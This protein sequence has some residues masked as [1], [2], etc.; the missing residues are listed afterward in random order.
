MVRKR[1]AVFLGMLAACMAAEM[2][3]AG[4]VSAQ[5]PASGDWFAFQPEHDEFG[6]AMLDLREVLNEPVA[7][8]RGRVRARGDALVF[9]K[10]GEPVRF[11]GVVI[12]SWSWPTDHAEIDYLARRLA[13]VGVNLVRVHIPRGNADPAGFL[14]TVHY[15]THAFKQ[16]GIYVYL[17]WFCTANQGDY[18]NLFYFDA[19]AQEQ[20]RAWARSILAPGNP[21]TGMSLATDPAVAAVELLDEDS[22][23]F[24]T[25]N[26]ERRAELAAKMPVLERRFGDWLA[27][28][29]GSLERAAAAWG[30]E[31]YPKGDDFAAGRAAMY[32]AY[33]LT[34]ADWAP[35]QRNAARARD[36]A[37]FMAELMRDFYGGTKAWMREELGYDGLV[38]GSNWKTADERVLGPL[39]QYANM[40]C[41]LTARN[42][43][44]SGGL[45]GPGPRHRIQQGQ[46]Y[47]NLSLLRAPEQAILMHLQV[48]GYPHMLTEGGWVAPNRFRAEE[49]FLVAGY[50]SLQGIDGYCPF[51]V[52]KDWLARQDKWPIQRPSTLG[53]YPAASVIYR[54]G[55]VR[56]GP[57]VINDV[58]S[59]DDLYALKG[60]AL[61]QPLGLDA[62]Q[63]A[64]VPEGIQAEVESLPGVD[65][66]SFYVGRVVRTIREKQG[67][68]TFMNTSKLI[69]R[70]ARVVRSA[71]GELVLDY[72]K[73]LVTMNAPRAQGAAGFLGAAG[74]IVLGDVAIRIENEYGAAM[75]VSLDG[76]PLARSHKILLQV[77]T[78]DRLSGWTT[79]PARA[80]LGRN[81]PEVDCFKIADTGKAPLMVRKIAGTVSLR[82][83]G[84]A[85]FKVTALDGNG[86]AR[87]RVA[88]GARALS[89]LPDCLY[90]VLEPGDD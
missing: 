66:L 70:R 13:K 47:T 7:G 44:F 49:P 39:D 57:V 33:L 35:G 74:E 25:F 8:S 85:S 36:Q 58:L 52:Q 86:Y 87:E 26:P 16:Q 34:G 11:W 64:R 32:P 73:G 24:H 50:Y 80:S 65:P 3:A 45:G 46:F 69:G 79:E 38:V 56:E 14:D 88:G 54:R 31:R 63:A 71:T 19:D 43:Y 18:T 4:R 60:A 78:E 37:E 6:P 22:L 2:T 76:E 48:A 17:L 83:P 21:Y 77:M 67:A 53:Q 72:G 30:G 75:V 40:A 81:Q 27:D 68:S 51:R 89:L 90:Y 41:D 28:R 62:I 15:M 1:W 23:F 12:E 29:Y 5:T 10:T 61:S 20:Y 9:E 84:S 59:L 55:Y 42:T 82:G